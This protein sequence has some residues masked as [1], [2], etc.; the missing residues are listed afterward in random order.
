[1]MTLADARS[2]TIF[3]GTTMSGKGERHDNAAMGRFF[4]T[5][6]AG[7]IWRS[8]WQGRNELEFAIFQYINGFYSHWRRHSAL[9]WKS[10]VA[11]GQK[12]A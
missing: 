7:S 1:M 10:P 3:R 8:S 9:A 4:K 6:K 5:I 2:R 11:F 12:V